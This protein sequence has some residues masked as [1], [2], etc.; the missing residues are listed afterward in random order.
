MQ[1]KPLHENRPYLR[2]S[3]FDSLRFHNKFS[4]PVFNG[5][6]F[7][8][9]ANS[10][11]KI[12]CDVL[13]V[14][15]KKFLPLIN[16]AAFFREDAH[17]DIEGFFD[18]NRDDGIVIQKR[19]TAEEG[20]T[21]LV[22]D[23]ILDGMQIGGDMQDFGLEARIRIPLLDQG[24]DQIRIVQQDQRL[25]SDIL[26]GHIVSLCE[27]MLRIGA[28]TAFGGEE[29][30][31]VDLWAEFPLIIGEGNIELFLL[32]HVRGTETVCFQNFHADL[33]MHPAEVAKNLREE[34][35]PQ[36]Q[37]K[38]EANTAALVGHILDLVLQF[39][40]LV[41]DVLHFREQPRTVLR[42]AELFSFLM[43]E[44]EPC[45]LLQGLHGHADGK[46]GNVQLFGCL[47]DV[48][49]LADLV[50]IAHLVKR[51]GHFGSPGSWLG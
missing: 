28:E 16:P 37:R 51:D 6:L 30:P 18:G 45:V 5:W 48:L 25:L 2:P 33:R 46:R 11:R 13:Q 24:I 40:R 7:L 43:K 22:A 34:P 47:C 35:R 27:R 17:M 39:L 14:F 26:Y 9:L 10:L 19:R 31:A 32:D 15:H 21:E 42:E 41:Q 23:K 49:P 1:R 36:L 38:G 50:E 12:P 8:W 3:G 44:M 29:F 20:G 4:H